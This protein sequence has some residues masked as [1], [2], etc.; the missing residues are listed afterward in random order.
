MKD[1]IE[2]L[3]KLLK[4]SD[5]EGLKIEIENEVIENGKLKRLINLTQEQIEF[6][7]KLITHDQKLYSEL[8]K[9]K[10]LK[11]LKQKSE[12]LNKL[13]KNIE[14]TKNNI[15]KEV[16][17]LKQQTKIK[18]K[19]PI[20]KQIKQKQQDIKDK[21]AI[22][23]KLK[24]I[25][26]IIEQSKHKQENK[27]LKQEYFEKESIKETLDALYKKCELKNITEIKKLEED[28]DNKYMK[29]LR[30]IDKD[31]EKTNEQ[32]KEQNKKINE[33]DK[34]LVEYTFNKQ[35]NYVTLAIDH[36]S[37]EDIKLTNND[38]TLPENI[39]H[40]LLIYG[41]IA[42]YKINNRE[43]TITIKKE[44]QQQIIKQRR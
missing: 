33:Y 43:T 38:I 21:E 23:L 30:K 41:L 22:D 40:E 6:M 28:L 15:K 2:K 17:S 13:K 34:R 9:L 18:T 24:R 39:N 8:E 16:E 26:N 27:N 42:I 31:I 3:K 20:L 29:I 44:E 32:Y 1:Y 5:I 7:L 36:L 10:N 14:E 25:I 19:I 12:D 37:K 4:K 11:K 35:N